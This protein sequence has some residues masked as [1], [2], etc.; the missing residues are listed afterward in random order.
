MV[1]ANI[2][3][4]Y[5]IGAPPARQAK[6]SFAGVFGYFY[7]C[8]PNGKHTYQFEVFALDIAQL[9][10]DMNTGTAAVIAQ[11][12]AHKVASTTLFGKY[13]K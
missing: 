8:P 6:D 5:Q 3:R 4:A 9:P 13:Q 2:T 1:A 10:T 12:V 7:P 11:I